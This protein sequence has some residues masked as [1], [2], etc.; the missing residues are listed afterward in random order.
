MMDGYRAVGRRTAGLIA[1]V[2]VL[3]LLAAGAFLW[4]R[5]D[6]LRSPQDL[7]RAA[8][9]A[10]P[11]RAAGMYAHLGDRLPQIKE[12]TTLWAAEAA[13][14]DADALAAIRNVI[15]YRPQSPVAYEGHVVLA[16]YYGASQAAQAKT[17]YE[18]ALALTNTLSL[19]LELA[20]YLE[21]TGDDAGA[22]THYLHALSQQP[23]AFAGVRRT[24]HDPLAVARDLIDATYFNDALD[25]LRTSTDPKAVP[26]RAEALAGAGRYQDAEAAYRQWLAQA[27]ADPA[28][29]SGLALV[30]AREGQT[31]AALTV[32]RGLNTNDSRLAQAD[33]LADLHPDQALP[34][35]MSSTFPVGWWSATA[36]LEAQKRLTETLPLYARV[37]ASDAV[38]ADDAAYRLYVL[39]Q[40]LGDKQAQSAGQALLTGLGPNYLAQRAA[41]GKLNLDLAPDLAPGGQDIVD[42]ASLLDALGRPD[43]AHFELALA[44]RH[45]TAPEV[46]LAMAQALSAR[47]DILAA[48]N[49]AA[50]YLADHP[51]APPAFWQL[52]YPRP[53]SA[54]VQS[55]AAEYQVDP[56]LIWSVMRAESKYAPMAVSGAGARGLMQVM[57]D[58]QSWIGEQ[59][60]E[61]FPPGAAF[62]P[63]TNVRMGA[64]YLHYLLEQFKGDTELAEAAYNGGPGS[65]AKWLSDPMVSNRDDWLRWIGFGQTREYVVRVGLYYQIYQMLYG[66][67][68][69]R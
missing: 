67:A 6:Y 57:P 44:A 68:G 32:Y 3:A 35:Y 54:T 2:V 69:G 62:V 51:Y 37:A 19:R 39:G 47:G 48:Q 12:Y 7:Y 50:L 42:K 30:L 24:G 25:T 27:P 56:L 1:I 61:V 63:E 31:D 64:W 23:D 9:S 28:A 18:A 52:S 13:M 4:I 45:Q 14:P 21:A 16:R 34:L 38:F 20:D 33:L 17:E 10:P 66:A 65:V 46:V 5:W 11:A 59:L 15:A 36:I 58:T 26:L 22:Y 8:S 29:Q 55:A 43:L 40:R 53:Y 49:A 60:G 41:G